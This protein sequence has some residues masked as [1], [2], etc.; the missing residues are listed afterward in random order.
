MPEKLKS[1]KLWAFI[2]TIL[3]ILANYIFALKMPMDALMSLVGMSSAY[4]LGQGYVD[5]K[6]QPVKELPIGDITNSFA[7]IIQTELAKTKTGQSLP[8][9]E[10]MNMFKTILSAELA[11]KTTFNIVP[12][13]AVDPIAVPLAQTS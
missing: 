12:V 3:I 4:I 5:G 13:V 10:L 7:E 1:R 9:D 8:L 11:K 2:G 6:Q